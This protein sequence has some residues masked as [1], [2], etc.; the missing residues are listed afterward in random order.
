MEKRIESYYY[1]KETGLPMRTSVFTVLLNFALHLMY[2]TAK[3][4]SSAIQRIFPSGIDN[5]TV[6]KQ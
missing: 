3:A 4:V 1:N 2:K 5:K 6:I